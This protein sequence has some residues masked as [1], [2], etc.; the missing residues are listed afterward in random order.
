[1]SQ[2]T[3]VSS[4][5]IPLKP[6]VESALRSEMKMLEIGLRRTQERLKSFEERFGMSSE[7]FY[8]RLCNDELEEILDFIEW[9]G[10]YK[11]LS[12]LYEKYQALKEIKI[13]DS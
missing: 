3:L 5:D 11:T 9:A 1:M 4:S 13:A 8:R 7:E 6:L 12:L 2:V 10:E